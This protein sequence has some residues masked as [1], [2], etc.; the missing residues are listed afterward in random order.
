MRSK[1]PPAR[2]L[3][4]QE[5]KIKSFAQPHKGMSYINGKMKTWK[6]DFMNQKAIER[7]A[8]RLKMQSDPQILV[9]E[10]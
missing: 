5:Y 9:C 8:P 6:M 10:L 4:L 3:F 7:L 1:I 2:S